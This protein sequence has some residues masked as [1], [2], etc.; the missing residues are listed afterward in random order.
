M[1][2]FRITELLFETLNNAFNDI[3]PFIFLIRIIVFCSMMFRFV[4]KLFSCDGAF[5]V[6]SLPEKKEKKEK[7]PREKRKPAFFKRLYLRITADERRDYEELID[8]ML[9]QEKA[10][11][12]QKQ[13][14]AHAP[15]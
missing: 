11:E 4:L 3:S 15:D 1:E 8:F 7:K 14:Q 5:F 9:L 12:Q 10:I 6:P 2:E 13:E